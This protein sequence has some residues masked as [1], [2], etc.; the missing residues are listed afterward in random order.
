MVRIKL[1]LYALKIVEQFRASAK[2]RKTIFPPV[3][4]TRFNNHLKAIA[5]AAGWAQELPKERSKRGLAHA[6]CVPGGRKQYRF[7]D[8]LSSHTM[9]RTA[10]STMLMLGMKE[11]VVKQISGH[12]SDS[13]SFYR[14]VNLV[15]S[16]VDNEMDAVFDKLS[17]VPATISAAQA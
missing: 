9:R 8:M 2:K 4:R 14:Y 11:H 5:E 16:Y 17:K 12:A 10:I 3:P 15:Q 6:S 1:P 13:K 7:C